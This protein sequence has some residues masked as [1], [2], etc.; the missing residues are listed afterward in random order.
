MSP[1][2]E[3][4]FTDTDCGVLFLMPRHEARRVAGR[5]KSRMVHASSPPPTLAP[6]ACPDHTSGSADDGRSVMDLNPVGE[7]LS[8]LA[9]SAAAGPFAPS[10]RE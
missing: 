7:T 4:M 8:D 2:P 6:T 9:D 3:K 1:A 10:S 5:R